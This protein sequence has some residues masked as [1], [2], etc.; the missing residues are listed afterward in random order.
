M[1]QFG[2][3]HGGFLRERMVAA[4]EDMWARFEEG[5]EIEFRILENTGED[6]PVEFREVED[7]ELASLGADI[8]DDV[9]GARFAESE[10]ELLFDVIVNEG[11]EGIDDEGVVLA[12][13]GVNAAN[14][15]PEFILMLQKIR[16]LDDLPRIGE[17]FRTVVGEVDASIVAVENGDAHFLFQIGDGFRQARL[18]DEKFLRGHA[19]GTRL[20]DLHDIA[21]LLK[22][23]ESSPCADGILGISLFYTAN[24]TCI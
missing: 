21:K 5:D 17:K 22:S 12:G 14:R 19:D 4:H 16:L 11:N 3:R 13:N 10:F 9:V 1:F 15:R 20:H 23:H 6:V 2:E 8:F 18:R 24:Y 7:A